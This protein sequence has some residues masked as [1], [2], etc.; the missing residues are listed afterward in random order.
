MHQTEEAQKATANKV[1]AD[2]IFQKVAAEQ[3]AEEER[4]E[5]EHA[6]K[7][8][9]EKVATE[10]VVAS[11]VAIAEASTVQIDLN[12]RVENEKAPTVAPMDDEDDLSLIQ[13]KG[14]CASPLVIKELPLR[15]EEGP[16][17]QKKR[18]RVVV[19]TARGK[20]KV[21]EERPNFI[22]EHGFNCAFLP[23][24]QEQITSRRWELACE[25]L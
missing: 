25:G 18:K 3:I 24:M 6:N 20:E 8:A 9:Q 22:E 16:N 15:Q 23:A 17:A 7:E 4:A 1:A 10:S 5:K 11:V 14:V 2:E 12:V 19:A 21:R 13:H